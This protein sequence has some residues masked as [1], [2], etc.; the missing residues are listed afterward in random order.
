MLPVNVSRPKLKICGVTIPEQAE[1]IAKLGVA[2]IGLVFHPKSKR[3]LSQSLEKAKDIAQIARANGAEPVGV[4]VDQDSGTIKDICELTGITTVQLHGDTARSGYPTLRSEF[5]CIYVIPVSEDGTL[6]ASHKDY[7]RSLDPSKD[8]LLFDGQQAGSGKSYSYENLL[9]HR[10]CLNPSIPMMVAGGV[11]LENVG[12]IL[13][14]ANPS[15]IDVSS[16]VE[17]SPGNKDLLSVQQ[18]IS[19]LNQ[20]NQERFNEFCQR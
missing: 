20:H 9:N 12:H 11:T 8:Y 15:V 13:D 17:M 7:V 2:F 6:L 16:S 14:V 10:D 4:F 5:S 18:F 1:Q 19:H 3:D